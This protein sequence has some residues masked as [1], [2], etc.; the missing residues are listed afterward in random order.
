MLEGPLVKFGYK[1]DQN[2]LGRGGG[3]RRSCEWHVTSVVGE[4]HVSD[5]TS[6]VGPCKWHTVD[7]E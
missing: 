5:V 3:G 6:A 2:S 7:A 4:A 1:F